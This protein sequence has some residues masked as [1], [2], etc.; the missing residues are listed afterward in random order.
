MQQYMSDLPEARLKPDKPFAKTAVDY[1]GAFR[2]KVKNGRGFRSYKAYV[3]IFVCM[4][5]RAIHIEAVSDLT[6]DAFIA[7]YRRFVSRRGAVKHLF[8]DN[9]TNF[10]LAN[11]IL[12]ENVESV[13]AY[14]HQNRSAMSWQKWAPSGTS[15][16]RVRHILMG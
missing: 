5:T 2:I 1:T 13:K 11:K 12:L 4:T 9:G 14:Y 15:H 6:A 16:H 8:S 7:A 3:S 10:V